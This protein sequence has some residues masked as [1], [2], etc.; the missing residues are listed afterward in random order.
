M[1]AKKKS[2]STRATKKKTR[3]RHAMPKRI[4][5]AHN[6]LLDEPARQLALMD[7]AGI[8]AALIMGSPRTGEKGNRALVKACRK[9]P[10]RF[11]GGAYYDP[12]EGKKAIRKLKRYHGEGLPVV[13]LFP[14]L[15]YF[16]DDEKVRPFFEKVAG[17]GMAVLSHCGW[18]GG[19]GAKMRHEPWAAY[20]SHPG[21]FEKVIRLFPETVFIMAHM[22]GIAGFLESVMLA[23]RTPNTYIDC[24][25]GQGLN[26][27]EFAP[28]IAG[29]VPP[30]KLL[31]GAD[32]LSFDA[33]IPRY[34]KALIGAGFGRHL[35]K[36][37]HDNAA[38]LFGKLGWTP[39][40]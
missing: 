5:D 3:A 38:E 4:I 36:V 8:E 22:G 15:G 9:H 40:D 21:R 26:V 27:L 37:F 14:N 1:A 17:L 13:K 24:S 30:T 16:P 10:H 6:H 20:Y 33:F 28:H 7:D 2:S 11:I 23:T 18:L 25:P 39:A 29:A 19:S 34:K 31:W 12:R 35:D 32:S